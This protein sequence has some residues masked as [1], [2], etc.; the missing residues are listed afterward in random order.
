[1]AHVSKLLTL[2]G[3]S[4]TSLVNFSTY[5]ANNIFD[6][7]LFTQHAS[8]KSWAISNFVTKRHGRGM[9]LTGSGCCG[10]F[11]VEEAHVKRH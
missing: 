1:M 6:L 10:V 2:F 3:K 4:G 11:T 7:L 9:W 8:E 5:E